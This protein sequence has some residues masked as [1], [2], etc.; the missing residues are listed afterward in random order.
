MLA[1]IKRGMTLKCLKCGKPILLSD[2]TL[3]MDWQSEYIKC[4]HC[5]SIYDVQAYHVHGEEIK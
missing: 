3:S 5:E 1:E 2:E 4:P